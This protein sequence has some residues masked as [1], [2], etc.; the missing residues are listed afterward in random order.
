VIKVY[1]INAFY[2]LKNYTS[3]DLPIG[4]KPIKNPLPESIRDRLGRL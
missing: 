4:M 2:G 1:L 3:P